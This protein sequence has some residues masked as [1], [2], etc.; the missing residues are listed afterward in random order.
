MKKSTNQDSAPIAA[1]AG[2]HQRL[3]GEHAERAENQAPTDVTHSSA[4]GQTKGR[5]PLDELED[6]LRSEA[7]MMERVRR[8]FHGDEHPKDSPHVRNAAVSNR[9]LAIL[10]DARRGTPT[11]SEVEEGA[12]REALVWAISIAL[13]EAAKAEAAVAGIAETQW[14]APTRGVAY[15]I[16]AKARA[17]A[18]ALSS[19]LPDQAGSSGACLPN[20]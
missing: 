14:T 17:K 11:E 20:S 1:P 19:L 10:V 9:W 3:V 13:N 2:P 7:A 12:V 16:A 18:K 8:L 4:V 15:G 5:V 6:H